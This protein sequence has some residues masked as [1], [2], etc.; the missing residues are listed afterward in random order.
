MA[1]GAAVL[2]A[3]LVFT[4]GAVTVVFVVDVVDA[5]DEAAVA[6]ASGTMPSCAKKARISVLAPSVTQVA[7]TSGA[8]VAPGT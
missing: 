4:F 3:L 2:R 8:V 1:A 7:T 6:H 5:V